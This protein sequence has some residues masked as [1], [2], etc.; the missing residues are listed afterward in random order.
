MAE[1][2]LET[3]RLALRRWREGDLDAWLTHLNTPEVRAYLGGV[4]TPEKVA[5]KFAKLERAWEANGFSFLA[6]DRRKD[7][8]FLGTCGM[9]RIETECAPEPLRGAVQI[10][11][12]LRADCWGRGYA[13]EAARAVLE[14][15][16]TRFAFPLVYAQ[17]SQRNRA[18]WGLMEKLGMRRLAELDYP[19][20]DYPPEDNPTI[21]YGLARE[22]WRAVAA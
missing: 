1:V 20:P 7:G 22:D 16:F 4:D 21:V 11:W 5:E 18:S 17:T 10:G 19:D 13:T 3:A 15:A 12:Q 14:M 9:A 6:V 2:V 8:A